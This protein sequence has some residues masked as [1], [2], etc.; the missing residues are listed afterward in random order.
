VRETGGNTKRDAKQDSG[1]ELKELNLVPPS[2]SGAT[3]VGQPGFNPGKLPG[4]RKAP[5][6]PM[7]RPQL[8]TLVPYP[9]SGD[10]WLHEIKFDGYRAI[11]R[12][13]D[14][15]ARFFTREGKDWT[16]RFGKLPDAAANLP[17]KNGILDGEIVVLLPDGRSS[18]QALQNALGTGREQP[19]YFAFDL[20]YLN[21]FDLTATPLLE[22]KKALSSLLRN[23]AAL[24]RYSDHFVGEGAELCHKVCKYALEGIVSKRA[25]S[26]YTPGRNRNWLKTKCLNSQEFIIGGFT[27]PAG[28]RTGFGS[29]LLGL[30]DGSAVRYSGRVGTGY[31]AETLK[32]LRSRLDSLEQSKPP[33][34]N[35]PAGPAARGVHWVKPELVAQVEFTGWTRDGMLRHPSFQG[36][37]EDK[38]ASSIRRETPAS[39]SAPARNPALGSIRMTNPDRVLYPDAGITKLELARY[40][41]IIAHW[42]MPQIKGRPLMLVRCPE[43]IAGEC[44]FQKHAS[45]KVPDAI[46][47]VPIRERKGIRTSLAVDSIDGIVALV[48]MGTLEIHIWGCRTDRLEQP[49]RMIFDL[50]PDASVPWDLVVEGAAEVRLRLERTGLQSWVKTTGGK[51]LHVVVPLIRRL[52][53]EEVKEFSRQ[54]VELMARESPGRYVTTASKAKRKGKIFIDYLRNARGAT[55]I[56]PYSCRARAGAPVATPIS[57]DELLEGIRPDQFNIRTIPERMKKLRN[58]PWGDMMKV[59]QTIRLR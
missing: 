46:H 59:R 3:A 8:A 25:G 34:S 13:D 43:G 26:P 29:L 33:F 9:P 5:L 15:K 57:W 28:S 58:D 20:L 44:F 18:F 56:A 50:D 53:W 54:V 47:Q 48:Q 49:D 16:E 4:A 52:R 19:V 32:E 17:L 36:L 40:Y 24:V 22:R 1:K 45:Q 11:C 14:G 42:M 37:R 12:I 27:E 38:P 2:A 31:T 55:A 30:R 35:P 23:P 41:Q 21:D 10:G 7:V 39:S 51:G 6:P